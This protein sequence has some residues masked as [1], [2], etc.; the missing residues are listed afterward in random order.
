MSTPAL[1]AGG[2][3]Y[4]V[5]SPTGRLMESIDPYTP[6]RLL[7][8]PGTRFKV[9]DVRSGQRPLVLL[10]EVFPQKPTHMTGTGDAHGE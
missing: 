5:R 4:A 9:L 1:G 6:R 7:F 2:P 8:L 3:G 10:R